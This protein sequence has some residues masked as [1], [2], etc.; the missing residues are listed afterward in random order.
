MASTTQPAAHKL[1]DGNL[2]KNLFRAALTWLE[3]NEDAVNSQN[4][5]PIPDGDT[6]VNMLKTMRSACNEIADLNTS[7]A[8]KVAKA[9]AHGAWMGG[10]GNSGVIL[11]Q[12]LRGFASALDGVD[13][14]GSDDLVRALA[15]ARDTA[16][17]GVG[18]PVEGTILTVIKDC[19]IA[20]EA[21]ASEAT[22]ASDMMNHVLEACKVSVQHTPELLPV[23]KQA[24][25]VD[26]GGFGLQVLFEG[27]VRYG[28]GESLTEAVHTSFTPID[29]SEMGDVLDVIEPGQE[30]EVVVDFR[31][32]REIHMQNFYTELETM[33]NSIQVGMGDELIKMHIHLLAVDR[34]RPI[35]YCETLGTVTEVSMENLLD[36]IAQTEP[37]L[38]PITVTE[39][40]ILAVSIVPGRGFAEKMAEGTVNVLVGGQTMNPSVQE[41]Q[42]TFADYPAQKIILLPNNKNIFMAAQSAAETSD[43]DVRVIK[44]RSAAAAAAALLNF[45]PNGDL[46]TVVADMEE[47]IEDL[48]LG[49]VTYAVRDVEID[50]VQV[51]E[52]QSIGL[53]N[54]KLAVSTNDRNAALMALLEKMGAEDCELLSMFYGQDV[55][56]ADAAE[57]VAAIEE[58]YDEMEIELFSGGQPHYQY[59]FALE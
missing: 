19:A 53:H 39:D 4:V 42:D 41:I 52:G 8:G 56:A 46:D 27:I 14:I 31:P 51:Q 33:G 29:I 24:G 6:G 3:T 44:T 59:I 40:Q 35:E 26:S 22:G 48:A 32:H 5:F 36:Q 23:L 15:S 18:K 11:S 1:V 38:P 49:D 9:A 17:R 37:Q 50:G 45:N 25:V 12:I 13:Q 21:Y 54:G 2:L 58:Q 47:T 30:W 20:A 55:S 7:S 10:S 16:Y 28:N 34:Y 57:T 43:K